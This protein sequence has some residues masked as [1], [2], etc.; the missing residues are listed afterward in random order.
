M[1]DTQDKKPI[2][3]M[4]FEER[5]YAYAKAWAQMSRRDFLKTGAALGG[6]AAFAGLGM[7][8]AHAAKPGGTLRIARGQ[9][10]DTLD[11][12]KTTLLV[13]HEIAWQIY[14][15][16]IYLD[17]TGT[18]YPGLATSWEFSN[19][20]KTVTLKLREGVNFHDG[21][22]FNAEVVRWTVERHLA[23]TTASPTSWM[24]GPIAGTEVIDD[25]TI[26]YH[27][28]DPF[29]PLWVGLGYSYC[30]PIS[31]AAVEAQGDAFGRN[32]S[33]TG[34]F[35]FVR[36]DPDQGIELVRN[37][38]HNWATPWY[39]NEGNAYL[40]R[41]EYVVIPEDATRLAA[42]LSGDVDCI[43]GTDAVPVDK[44]RQIEATPGYKTYS[45]PAVGVFFAMM[46]QKMA[47]MDDVRVRQAINYAVNREK[48]IALVLDGQGQSAF[49]P[50]ASSYGQYNAETETYGYRHDPEK[51]KALM[52][53]AGL[54]DGFSMTYLNIESPAYRRVA[55][56][57]QED[58]SQINISM[59][60][61][62]YPV[63]EWF[64]LG[65]QGKFHVSFFYYTYSDPD[66]IYPMML[67]NGAY[68]W[69]FSENAEMDAL[70]EAQRIEFDAAK[71]TEQIQKIQEIAVKDAY[72]IYLYEGTYVAA[73]KEEV[74]GLELNLVGFHHLQDVWL[75]V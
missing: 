67:T 31:K 15:S 24:L 45:R 43:S 57:I 28:T 20:G 21:S 22:P 44:L 14:D 25:M 73:M 41:V 17:E 65:G 27:Y 47:P 10:S 53:E 58:L 19:E 74:Q 69:T 40:E 26:A 2:A 71:R 36:W 11:P 38:E 4:T 35:K 75:D 30:A 34:P 29:V 46:N 32:P 23:D 60:I 62:S 1:T 48:I 66:L 33:G 52:A 64:A 59:E 8:R 56:V 63:A 6:A 61:Q 13:A 9:E 3:D 37:D 70:I 68:N 39:S 72:W 12:Q 7:P 49:S 55:E 18:V 5:T 50:V 16:L 42:L 54:A 51:A